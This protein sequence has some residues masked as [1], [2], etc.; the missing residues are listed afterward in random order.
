LIL[1]IFNLQI[2]V[3]HFNKN[4]K[5]FKMNRYTA[6]KILLLISSVAFFSCSSDAQNSSREINP[7]IWVRPGYELSV[8][9]NSDERARHMCIGPDGTLYYTTTPDKIIMAAKDKDND[10]YYETLT[11][12]HVSDNGTSSVLWYD[13]WLWYTESGA[14][15]K[16][17]DNNNDGVADEKVTVIPEGSLP[18]GGGHNWRPILILNGRIYTAIGD[19]GN[20]ND[21]VNTEREKIWSFNLEG[22]DKKLWCSGIRNT[23]KLVVRPG[24][25]EIWGMDHGSD[26]FGK[27]VG[28]QF[29]MQ[30][31]TDYNPPGEMNKYVE[32]GFYGHP[33]IVGNR[34]PRYEYMNRKDIIELAAKTIVPEWCTGAHWAPNGMM[35]YTGDQFPADHI[36]DAFVSFHGSWNRS[37]K[38]GYEVDRVLFED[39]KPYGEKA[40]VK[41]LSKDQE[42]L[43]RPVDV[44]QAADG[45]LLISEDYNNIIYRLK[46]V[47]NK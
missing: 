29:G 32:G 6:I 25:D 44:I 46:Y 27:Q 3:R 2:G 16:L 15:F 37:K 11:Q 14:I 30:P 17:R 45:S 13:G 5:G 34:V 47:G 10:G 7:G 35:F 23:E 40:Y 4:T 33:F 12:F 38:A 8:A 28:D 41:F 39:G 43:G 42:V 20:I 22:K 36:G 18:S 19:E 31:I 9:A 21:L 1:S 26:W 24:T